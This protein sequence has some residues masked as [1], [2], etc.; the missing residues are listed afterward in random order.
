MLD[1]ELP[2]NDASSPIIALFI[3]DQRFSEQILGRI[4]SAEG[5]VSVIRVAPA[6]LRPDCLWPDAEAVIVSLPS[7]RRLVQAHG[8]RWLDYCSDHTVVLVMDSADFI[9][10]WA[11]LEKVEGIWFADAATP[12]VKVV[13]ALAKAGLSVLPPTAI[14]DIV[15]DRLRCDAVAELQGIDRAIVDHLAQAESNGSIARALG[16]TE[17]SVKTRVR[18]LLKLLKCQNRTE[19]AVFV[20]GLRERRN[21]GARRQCPP[22]GLKENAQPE[23]KRERTCALA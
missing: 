12:S 16:L 3:D 21:D 7:M 14:M 9:D 5:P 17:A 11:F 13:V 2:M 18:G 8:D 20:A 6:G 15:S 10:S 22:A 1:M 19:A 4:D 23:M